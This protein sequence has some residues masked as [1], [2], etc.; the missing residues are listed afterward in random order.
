MWRL[1]WFL[2]TLG[3]AYMIH[4]WKMAHIQCMSHRQHCHK[5]HMWTQDH[6]ISNSR[7]SQRSNHQQE[8]MPLATVGHHK[9]HHQQ[10]VMPLATVGYHKSHI[11]SKRSCHQQQYGI[12]KVTSLARGHA[13]SNSKGITKVT[14]LARGHAISNSMVSQKSHHQPE[15]MP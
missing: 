11:T 7:V 10:E 13:I 14:S 6:A 4:G 1:L 3:I 5:E 12:T 15:V 9:R 2:I 8:V